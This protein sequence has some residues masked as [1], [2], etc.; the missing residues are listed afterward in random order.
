[1]NISIH[2]PGCHLSAPLLPPLTSFSLCRLHLAGIFRFSHR[3]LL[4]L[5]N[6]TEFL[7]VN[8][9]ERQNRNGVGRQKRK[10]EREVAVQVVVD[11]MMEGGAGCKQ[12]EKCV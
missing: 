5:R 1:M 4:L 10:G 7:A 6:Q 3:M 2:T 11:V 8:Q 9:A 12:M